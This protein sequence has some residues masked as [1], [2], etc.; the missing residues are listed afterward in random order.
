[1]SLMVSCLLCAPLVA[2]EAPKPR[3]PDKVYVPYEKLKG[4]FESETQGVFLPYKE[5]QRLWQAAK[6]AP[7]GVTRAP[8]PYLISKAQFAGTVGKELAQIQLELTVDILADGWVE[9]PVGLGEVAIAKAAFA[10]PNDKTPLLLRV[11]KGRYLLV[12]RGKGRRV[13]KLDFVRQLETKPG[14]N[15]L[16]FRIPSAAIS[17]LDLLIP[18][19]NMK[20]DVAPMLAATTSQETVDGTKATRL[21]TFLGS[22]ASVRLSWKPKTQA[23]AE[24]APVVISDQ[25]QHINV[26][27]AL[28]TH[29]V[30]FTYDIRRRGVDSFTVQLPPDFRVVSVTGDNI[31]KWDIV[32]PTRVAA[33][34]AL[35]VK[36]FSPVKD[37]YAL[38]VKME[39][40][41]KDADATIPIVPIITQQVLRRTGLIAITHSP[42][43]SVEVQEPGELAR[44]DTGRLPKQLRSSP[45]VTAHRFISADY[46]GKLAI[47]TVSPRIT[48][49]HLWALGVADDRLEL[50]GQLH[51]TIE[52]VGVFRLET[53]LPEPWE[54]VSVGPANLVDDHQL[55]G[56]GA[57]RKLHLLLKK[58]VAGNVR[59][60]LVARAPRTAPDA[61]VNFDL[62]LADA[63]DV[64][65]YSGQLVLYLAGRLRAEVAELNQLQSLP[66]SRRQ[67]GPGIGGLATAMA[68]EFRAVDR[69]R[70]A[71][72]EFRIAVRP[73]QVSAVVHRL[74]NIQA[75]SVEQEARI[76]YNVLYAPVDTFYLK[77]PAS[78]ADAGVQITGVDIKEKPRIDKLPADQIEKGKPPTTQPAAPGPAVK[79]IDWAYYKVVLQSPVI[80][81]YDV[82]VSARRAFQAAQVGQ[83]VTVPVEPILA[84]GKLS[85]QS[86]HIAVAKAETLAIVEPVIQGLDP[87]DPSSATDLPYAPHRK[88]ASLA[89]RYS[90][91]PFELS[92]P[93]VSQ[94]EAAVFTTIATAAIIE[95]VIARDGQLNA[96]ATFLL[97][98]SKGDRL[99]IRM[100]EGAKLLAVLLNGSEVPVELGATADDRIVRLPPSAGQVTKL[101]LEIAYALDD[102]S[103]WNLAA[104]ALPEDIPVQQTL[105]RLWV[106]DEEYM[107]HFDRD[108]SRLSEGDSLLRTLARGQPTPV[109]FKLSPQ[110]RVWD[111]VRQGPPGELSVLLMG[112]ELFNIT[113]WVLVAA[114]GIAMLKLGGF[115]RCLILLGAALLAAVLRLF[116]PLLVRNLVATATWAAVLVLGLWI[117]QWL[118]LR[119]PG[120]LKQIAANSPPKPPKKPKR[121]A[122][123]APAAD[124]PDTAAA[125]TEDKE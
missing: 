49:R 31:S 123:P 100:P 21:Q 102:A 97:A 124:A 28:I 80:G 86:G 115:H 116:S 13:L 71:G 34:P 89:F 50:S 6:G 83:A 68:F 73:A 74:V 92:L 85:D 17:K 99:P 38:S 110:G 82:R 98:T 66:L 94:K 105:W 70:P 84:A 9:V 101:V 54:I 93:V 62:P 8:A 26:A 91:P 36:L 109:A 114:G 87:A 22:A 23:A 67:G 24:L 14:L 59:I 122:K 20:V 35:Q 27:E 11:V 63:T 88:A 47:G 69:A 10:E 39:R 76:Q 41:L 65:L 19:E 29:E 58:E 104:P 64:Q 56:S 77:M 57:T 108:F 72:A 79:P 52:R 111:F 4:V 106:P 53:N 120:L 40:F 16:S 2:Q 43:R 118:F 12:T 51:Y 125:N 18:E 103:A 44:V 32:S 42:R 113:I 15:I 95:Q 25:F 55:K 75:G 37:R 61:D 33:P 121:P 7:A 1:M 46:S 45:G 60:D 5:F 48:A 78:L 117:A 119:L 112:I 30:R 81:R 107:L 3:Q 96:H 90:R